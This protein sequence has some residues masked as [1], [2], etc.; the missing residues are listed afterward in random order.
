MQG[1]KKK[2]QQGKEK[3]EKALNENSSQ[4]LLA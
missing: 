1:K 4:E 3:D 2:V